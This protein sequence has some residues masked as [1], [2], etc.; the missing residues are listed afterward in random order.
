M[1]R[2]VSTRSTGRSRREDRHVPDKG[3]DV[4]AWISVFQNTK[5]TETAP[6]PISAWLFYG[7][8]S[9]CVFSIAAACMKHARKK[10]KRFRKNVNH[11]LA[12][13]PTPLWVLGGGS[14]AALPPPCVGWVTRAAARW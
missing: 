3:T 5:R 6:N 9:V 1:K 7:G 11:G 10:K 2:P 4:R 12:F 13:A 8:E 14:C